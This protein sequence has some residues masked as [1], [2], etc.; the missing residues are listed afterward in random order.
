MRMRDHKIFENREH[1]QKHAEQPANFST[2][3]M[4]EY[5]KASAFRHVP[6]AHHLSYTAGTPPH[7]LIP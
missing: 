7:S 6:L 3:Q 1:F 2:F 4:Q 5:L